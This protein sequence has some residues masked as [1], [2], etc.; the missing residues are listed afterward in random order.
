MDTIKKK[1]EENWLTESLGVWDFS[2][3]KYFNW[4]GIVTRDE[5]G[6][7]QYNWLK[8]SK[9]SDEYFNFAQV[10]EGD[11][12]YAGCKN[13]YKNRPMATAY[14]GV[15]K[16]NADSIELICDTTYLKV[17]KQLESEKEE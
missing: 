2:H 14:Y 12:L 13:T 6:N 7:N 8:A 16:K 9:N 11:I 15:V 4:I 3:H 10:K 17:K 5:N 1:I